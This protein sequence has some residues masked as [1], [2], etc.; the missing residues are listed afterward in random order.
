M[1]RAERAIAALREA[2][3]AYDALPAAAKTVTL[4]GPRI[5]PATLRSEADAIER[6]MTALAEATEAAP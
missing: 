1:T 6:R 2:A 3:D 5:V 4:L